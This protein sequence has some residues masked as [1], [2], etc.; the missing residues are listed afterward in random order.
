MARCGRSPHPAY[1]PQF[2]SLTSA[3]NFLELYS[4]AVLTSVGLFWKALWAFIL[5]YIVS[6]A[7]QV[8]VT[9]QRMQKAMGEAGR[10]S[11]ALATFF[12]FISPVAAD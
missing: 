6:S 3:T 4:E 7:I 2:L 9:R 1:S 10:G 5:G 8:F 11:V 12:G